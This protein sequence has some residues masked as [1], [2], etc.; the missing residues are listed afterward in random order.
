M[1]RW[2]PWALWTLGT[3]D[4]TAGAPVVSH[5]FEIRGWKRSAVEKLEA[6]GRPGTIYVYEM[7][8]K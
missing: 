8:Q 7:G 1:R 6:E 4:L 2:R 3:V 5:D